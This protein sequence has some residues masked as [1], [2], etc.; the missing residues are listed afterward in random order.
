MPQLEYLNFCDSAEASSQLNASSG[1]CNHSQLIID[2][3]KGSFL[4]ALKTSEPAPQFAWLLMPGSTD[5]SDELI[6]EATA[7][8]VS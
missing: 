7:F 2:F 6:I 4:H 5:E 8:W 3:S 1:I